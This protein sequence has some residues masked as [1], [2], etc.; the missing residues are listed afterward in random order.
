MS[1]VQ[2]ASRSSWTALF[3]GMLVL[4]TTGCSSLTPRSQAVPIQ[5]SLRQACPD[6]VELADSKGATVLAWI[7]STAR[8]YRICQDRHRQLVQAI[9]T[10][11]PPP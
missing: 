9:A 4:T 6:L 1:I 5:A 8:E 10:D 3:I 11:S 2:S 7:R